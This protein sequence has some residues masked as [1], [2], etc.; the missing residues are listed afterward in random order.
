MALA[1]SPSALVSG[2]LGGWG[3]P[4]LMLTRGRGVGSDT[5][6]NINHE[7][8]EWQALPQR[9]HYTSRDNPLHY[10]GLPNHLH[11]Q[12]EETS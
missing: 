3:S 4:S 8:L 6:T 12:A 11:Y 9:M 5:T 2:G 7:T 10:N 1:G